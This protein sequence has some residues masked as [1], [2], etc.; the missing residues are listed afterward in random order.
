MLTMKSNNVPARLIDWLS[1]R[2]Q[3]DPRVTST[4]DIINNKQ[5]NRVH[6]SAG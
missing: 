6:D 4:Y 3:S 1:S 5:L 2:S